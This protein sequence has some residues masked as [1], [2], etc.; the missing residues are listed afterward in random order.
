MEFQHI[1]FNIE[2]VSDPYLHIH[3]IASGARGQI[4]N[5]FANLEVHIDFYIAQHFCKKEEDWL[6]LMEQIL[7]TKMTFD[8]KRVVLNYLLQTY[9]QEFY[10]ANKGLHAELEKLNKIRNE[11]AHYPLDVTENGMKISKEMKIPL[12]KFSDKR[13]P[14]IYTLEKISEINERIVKTTDLILSLVKV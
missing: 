13:N 11:F 8:Q 9:N 14:V 6:E 2:S 3:L 10:S 12:V 7:S 5:L 4:L 1:K